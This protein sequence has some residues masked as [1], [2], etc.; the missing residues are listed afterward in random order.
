[1]PALVSYIQSMRAEVYASGI[2]N[3]EQI[4]LLGRIDCIGYSTSE[5]YIG[6]YATDRNMSFSKALSRKYT[7]EGTAQ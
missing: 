4:R 3:D 7:E 2:L 6:K 5:K 1:M